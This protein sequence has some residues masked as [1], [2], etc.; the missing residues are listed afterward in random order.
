MFL[1]VTFSFN[2]HAVIL[3][4]LVQIFFSMF[5]ADWT[6]SKS[7]T[8]PWLICLYTLF[9]LEF[10]IFKKKIANFIQQYLLVSI[11]INVLFC[12][13]TFSSFFLFHIPT[14]RCSF[15][16]AFPI[17]TKA[18]LLNQDI[19][20]AMKMRFFWVGNQNHLLPNETWEHNL[21]KSFVH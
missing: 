1:K 20:S 6:V 11:S 3:L 4:P 19:L 10:F 14:C 9:W 16:D 5:S 15:Q 12:F 18:R 8:L 2:T 21:L 7:V 17:Y 13:T